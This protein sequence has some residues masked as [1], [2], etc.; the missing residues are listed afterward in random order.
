MGLYLTR[1][2]AQTVL[3]MSDRAR[4]VLVRMASMTLDRSTKD[5]PART[6]FG[7]WEWL[8]LPWDDG[9][10]TPAAL[11]QI[12]ARAIRELVERG[13]V[14]AITDARHRSTQHY[15]VMVDE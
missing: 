5:Q 10:R 11:K 13:Y 15:V 2:C 8:S 4:I 6:Y 12:V 1:A 3:P 9:T 7:G 14:K